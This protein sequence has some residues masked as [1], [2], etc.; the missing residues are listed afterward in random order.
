M[1]KVP[2][3]DPQEYAEST[4]IKVRSSYAEST[5]NDIPV[6]RAEHAQNGIAFMHSWAVGIGIKADGSGIGIAASHISVRY[7]N[8]APDQAPYFETGLAPASAFFLH[9]GT[10][11]TECRTVNPV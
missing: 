9:T 1:P 3:N 4:L 10:G 7:R 6:Y 5:Q 8:M 2:G 11:L